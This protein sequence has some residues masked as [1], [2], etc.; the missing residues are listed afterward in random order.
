MLDMVFRI[1]FIVF[2]LGIFC[3][4]IYKTGIFGREEEN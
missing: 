2:Y 3:W 4:G 1:A